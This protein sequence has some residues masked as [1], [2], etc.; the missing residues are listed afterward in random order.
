MQ[1]TGRGLGRGLEALEIW[2]NLTKVSPQ[3]APGWQ[4]P[5]QYLILVYKVGKVEEERKG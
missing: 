1:Y 2:R 4:I 5:K 3:M